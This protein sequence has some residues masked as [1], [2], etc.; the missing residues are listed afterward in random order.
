MPDDGGRPYL[1][2]L[3]CPALT[4]TVFSTTLILGRSGA[5]A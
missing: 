5:I 3:A 1:G 2:S 4:A